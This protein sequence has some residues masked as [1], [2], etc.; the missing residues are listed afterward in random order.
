MLSAAGIDYATGKDTKPL[1]T[2]VMSATERQSREFVKECAD[3]AEFFS[4]SDVRFE[5]TPKATVLEFKLAGTRITALP[6]TPRAVRGVQGR[7]VLDEI[8]FMPKFE[9]IWGAAL[10]I[11]RPNLKDPTGYPVS[12]L[13][14]PWARGT[15]AFQVLNNPEYALMSVSLEDALRDGF[16]LPGGIERLKAEIGSEDIYNVEYMCNWLDTG[17]GYFPSHILERAVVKASND[18]DNTGLATELRYGKNAVVWGWDIGRKHDLTVGAKFYIRGHIWF[19]VDLIVMRGVPL[20]VQAATAIDAMTKYPSDRIET[21]RVDR[22]VQ[23]YAVYDAFMTKF[24]DQIVKSADLNQ[25]AQ[26]KHMMQVKA[27]LE[28]QQLKWCN[29][30]S[31]ESCRTLMTEFLKIEQKSTSGGRVVIDTPRDMHGHC[32]RAWAVA[33]AVGKYER[34][35]PR[36]NSPL[37][38]GVNDSPI[39]DP[40]TYTDPMKKLIH[41][42]FL[43]YPE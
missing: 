36:D 41:L 3:L 14:T 39:N 34:D 28:R 6:S 23:G 12:V 22:G 30:F 20:D 26:V 32:D 40:K 4:D 16:P 37:I 9:E 10:P 2:Y 7:L 25:D 19:L 43:D 1:S 13:S 8:C 5:C 33:I 17:L 38:I 27:L 15:K 24:G 31:N 18:V 29:E 35:L 42:G 21:I 11:S